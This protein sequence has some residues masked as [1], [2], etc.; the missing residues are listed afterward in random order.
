MSDSNQLTQAEIDALLGGTTQP[1]VNVSLSQQSLLSPEE[2]ASFK[3]F[4]DDV[5]LSGSDAIT[6]IISAPSTIKVVGVSELTK[7]DVA[8]LYSGQK[9]HAVYLDFGEPVKGR[10]HIYIKEPDAMAFGDMLLGADGTN[11]SNDSKAQYDKALEECFKRFGETHIKNVLTQMASGVSI[12]TASSF[13]GIFDFNESYDPGLG[14]DLISYTIGINVEF[15][16]GQNKFGFEAFNIM[17]LSLARTILLMLKNA[18]MG[19]VPGAAQAQPQQAPMQQQAAPAQQAAQQTFTAAPASDGGSMSQNE[20]EELLRQSAQSAA[21][22]EAPAP[23]QQAQPAFQQPSFTQPSPQAQPQQAAAQLTPQAQ[24]QQPGGFPPQQTPQQQ[25]QQAFPQQGGFPPQQ[26]FPQQ[27][28]FPPQQMPPQQQQQGFPQQGGFPPQQMPPQGYPQ[29]F[30]QM[31]GYPPQQ[32][33]QQGYPQQFGQM[34][35]YPPQQMPQQGYP[36]QFIQQQPLMD[37]Q[38][39]QN[40]QPARFSALN[41]GSPSGATSNIELL[42][43][44][45]L[46]LTVELGRTKMLIK[47]IL[48][49]TAGSIVELDKIAGESIDVL[50]NNKLVAKGEV[51]VID[52]NFGIRITNII[53]PQER[54]QSIR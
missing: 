21:P 38:H 45:P 20:I 50:I 39:P 34:G 13:A 6:N 33:P 41:S 31:G 23:P 36:P 14:N 28:G 12:A 17:P 47:D 43:D 27:G 42:L 49:L 48:D 46:T 53:S 24:P 30:G 1:I 18:A 44:V 10:T 16:G 22:Q 37:Q 4:V 51:V 29:Q 25:P 40:V 52:E 35:G 15:N 9:M 32:M 11:P 3:K 26:G 54:L 2:T 5:F 7:A 8:K 19:I